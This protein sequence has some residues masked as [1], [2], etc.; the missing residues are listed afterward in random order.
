MLYCSS[1]R[2]AAPFIVACVLLPCAAA[3]PQD[4]QDQ[5]TQSV[6]DAAR[7]ARG[8]KKTA[9]KSSKVIT[10]DDIESKNPKPGA[11]GA[12]ASAPPKQEAQ[13]PSTATAA[14]AEATD[15]GAASVAKDSGQKTADGAEIVKLKG[16]IAQIQKDL[17]LLQREFVLDRDSYYSQP[18]FAHDKLG[19]AK[20][21]AEQ[22]LINEKQQELDALKTRLAALQEL[23]DRKKSA[24]AEAGAPSAPPTPA[25]P[26]P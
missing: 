10:D 21:D 8:Q 26:Q 4:S 5:Q 13:T 16:Q 11:Q 20:L 18:D 24:S 7:R 25:P 17:D 1:L 23:Q 9:A 22:Q 6:A 3:Q 15:Q 2:L 12:D 14:S 19:K